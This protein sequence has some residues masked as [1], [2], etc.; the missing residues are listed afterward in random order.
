[1]FEEMEF[2]V[3]EKNAAQCVLSFVNQANGTDLKELAEFCKLHVMIQR[4]F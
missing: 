2:F 4:Y 1:M 3:L